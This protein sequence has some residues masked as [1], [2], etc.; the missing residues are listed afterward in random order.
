VWLLVITAPGLL[1]Q[2]SRCRQQSGPS[3]EA[4]APR[5]MPMGHCCW[6]SMQWRRGRNRRHRNPAAETPRRGIFRPPG[7]NAAGLVPP[8]Q[9]ETLR[10]GL[11]SAPSERLRCGPGRAATLRICGTHRYASMIR[12]VLALDLSLCPTPAAALDTPWTSLGPAAAAALQ[13]EARAAGPLQ[14]RSLQTRSLQAARKCCRPSGQVESPAAAALR[15]LWR[16]HGGAAPP[17]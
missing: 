12:P 1:L 8:W 7:W 6:R 17:G 16:R 10:Y 15:R 9:R 4:S 5:P 14:T 3:I 2:C 13:P 11:S